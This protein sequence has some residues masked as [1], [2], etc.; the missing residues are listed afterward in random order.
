MRYVD[1]FVQSLMFVAVLVITVAS[2]NDNVARSLV[3]MQLIVGSWQFVSSLT[4]VV[5]KF[6]LYKL[7][8]MH[9]VLCG[10]YLSIL[11]IVPFPELSIP[12]SLIILMVP[13]WAL[14]VCY[15]AITCLATFQ[16]HGR[17]SSFLPHT[18]F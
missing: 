15:Y 8:I 10:I 2:I 7:K 12:T 9:L 16:H 4:S 14:A 17:Q 6:R 1:F 18:S 11:F 3:S 13:A 5:L